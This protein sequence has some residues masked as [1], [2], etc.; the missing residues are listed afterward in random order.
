[1]PTTRWLGLCRS[2][3]RLRVE[4]DVYGLLE[5]SAAIGTHLD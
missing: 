4:R 5:S 2:V 3:G 1:M